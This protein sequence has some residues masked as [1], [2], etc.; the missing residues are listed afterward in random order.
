MRRIPL[1]PVNLFALFF[2]PFLVSIDVS[3]AA[4]LQKTTLFNARDGKYH[5][6]RIPGIIASKQGTLLAYCEA[7]ITSGDWANIDILLRRS[8]DGGKTWL[9]VQMIHD[10]KEET[11]NNVVA[12]SDDQTGQVHLL[13]CENYSRCFYISSNDDGKTFSPRVE[14][15]SVF[16]Q[17]K[18]E[19]DWNVIA[20]GPGHGIQLQN[21]RL[22]VPVWLSTGGKKHRPSCVST[23]FSDD[24]G[25]TWQRGEIIV[26]QGDQ[27]A[28]ET[29]VNPSET[30]AVQLFNNKVLVN[31]RTE[32]K[33]HRRLVAVSENGATNWTD[34]H[35]DDQ[36]K[37]PVC[38][39][40]ILRVPASKAQPKNAIVFANP[41]NLENKTKRRKPNRDRK[42]LTL[43]VSFDDCQTW[44]SKQVLEP[45]ISG[46]S[47]LAALPDGT[48]FC[49]YEDG[50][51]KN[52]GYDTTALTVAKFPLKWIIQD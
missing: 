9:P 35:F 12:F 18:K 21:G 45:G 7:R 27:V 50:G 6:Y 25:K 52:N 20:T 19:Y 17:F 46:Y 16:N 33:P 8:T 39:A 2:V 10:A 28:G 22:L 41:D 15:T 42:N 4:D 24:H 5:H 47:D 32:S 34:K 36:L 30:V 1:R 23:I 13:Y 31:I 14:I 11:V 43:Q 38:M 48:I 49:F 40:S 29:I 44:I 37:E 3:Q 26:K 51:F